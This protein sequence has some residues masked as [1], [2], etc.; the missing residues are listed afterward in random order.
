[1]VSEDPSKEY[2]GSELGYIKRNQ[3]QWNRFASEF[4]APGRQAWASREPYWGVWSIPESKASILPKNIKGLHTLELGCGTAYV[5]AWLRSAGAENTPFKSE[6]FDLVISEYGACLWSDPYVW[7]PE[8][9]RI[10]KPGGEL[11]FL[12]NSFLSI[13]CQP[14]EPNS[15]IRNLLVRPQFDLHRVEWANDP[16]DTGV[17]FHLSHGNWIKLFCENDLEVQDLL[18]LRPDASTETRFDYITHE[19]SN[20]WAAEEV[21]KL[22]KKCT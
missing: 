6:T 1:M 2:S 19:W 21:W 16:Q 7:I 18:E 5:S 11:I 9:S 8:A 20:Q 12:T 13:L 14:D 15:S 4:S 10:L 22:Q 3:A 17:E